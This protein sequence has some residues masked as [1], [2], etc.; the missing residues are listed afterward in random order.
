MKRGPLDDWK[1]E[2]ARPPLGTRMPACADIDRCTW[3][4]NAESALR[5]GGL[6]RW[7]TK[8]R[9]LEMPMP[10]CLNARTRGGAPVSGDA[11]IGSGFYEDR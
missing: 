11:I 7:Q 9:G 4:L 6:P 3:V 5:D 2:C 8:R 10:G 1:K